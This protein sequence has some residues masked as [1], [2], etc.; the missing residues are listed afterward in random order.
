MYKNSRNKHWKDGTIKQT[1]GIKLFNEQGV[2]IDSGF[3]KLEQEMELERHIVYIEEMELER[4]S[5]YIDE[6]EP[7][8]HSV[9]DKR[10]RKDANV[11]SYNELIK[12]L[13]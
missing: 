4:H 6:M 9:Q 7:E 11:R 2:E 1:Q 5:V 13:G 12:A 10:P 3:C 8:R